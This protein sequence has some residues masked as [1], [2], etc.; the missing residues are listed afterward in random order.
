MA[1]LEQ[2]D[3]LEGEGAG[4]GIKKD[5]KLDALADKFT[6]LRDEKA[7]LAEKMTETEGKIIE[8][9]QEV[10][11]TIYRY[12][13]REVRIKPGNPHV[14]VKTVTVGATEPGDDPGT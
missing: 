5:K 9:M 6:D 11:I 1:K 4:V 8:R 13:D 3:A 7:T 2:T 14:K 12:A 10:G